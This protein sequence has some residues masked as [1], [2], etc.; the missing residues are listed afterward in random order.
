MGVPRF[1]GLQAIFL[2]CSLTG[3]QACRPPIRAAVLPPR[4]SEH[5][6]ILV[7]PEDAGGRSITASRPMRDLS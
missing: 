5:P 2:V 7:E 4:A 3:S 6:P 1:K